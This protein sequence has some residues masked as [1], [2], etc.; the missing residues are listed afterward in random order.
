MRGAFT[1]ADKAVPGLIETSNGGCCLSM[2]FIGCRPSQEK[3]FHFMDNGSWRRLR[4]PTAQATVRLILLNQDLKTLP[5]LYSPYSGDCKI[6]PIAERGHSSGWR[7][8]T[9]FRRE[10]QR[11][12]H[13]PGWRNQPA[14]A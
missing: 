4:A 13:D 9:T 14:N 3:L 11:L 7:L 10:A 2:R 6:L 5:D 1:G 12:N 8:S